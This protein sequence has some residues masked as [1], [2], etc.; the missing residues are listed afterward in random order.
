LER[1]ALAGD[2]EA[3]RLLRQRARSKPRGGVEEVRGV[4][5]KT[6]S[7]G[8]KPNGVHKNGNVV[9]ELNDGGQVIAT[10]D[11]IRV[12]RRSESAMSLA[13]ELASVQ[14]KAQSLEVE[15]S[16]AFQA[17]LARTA[18]EQAFGVRF[19]S[20]AM[21]AVREATAGASEQGS[22]AG[23]EAY[24]QARKALRAQRPNTGIAQHRRWTAADAGEGRYEGRRHFADGSEAVLISRGD[25]VLVH[26]ASSAQAAKA[27]TWTIGDTV[28][29]DKRGRFMG[30]ARRSR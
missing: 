9:Y 6:G 11:A 20:A 29:V 5:K 22:V 25:A 2:T 12:E 30:S 18:V 10:G 7:G 16:D 17:G 15:G 27:S 28:S 26:K 24:N 21:E 14:F 13:L 3:L 19:T 4:G 23:A 8:P 1:K